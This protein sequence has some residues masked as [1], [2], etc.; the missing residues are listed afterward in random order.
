MLLSNPTCRLPI[1][2]LVYELQ[3]HA[4]NGRFL[5][6]KTVAGQL[7]FLWSYTAGGYRPKSLAAPQVRLF[8]YIITS[9]AFLGLD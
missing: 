7:L 3:R 9:C 8:R 6:D 4:P 5:A 2:V 1:Y